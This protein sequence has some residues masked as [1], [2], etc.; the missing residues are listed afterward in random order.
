MERLKALRVE[1]PTDLAVIYELERVLNH[2]VVS[3]RYDSVLAGGVTYWVARNPLHEYY[4]WS[5]DE[6]VVRPSLLVTTYY[7][8]EDEIPWLDQLLIRID[9]REEPTNG[10]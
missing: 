3:L 10:T 6:L 9:E 8:N 7:W 1:N 5:R 4:A 2:R